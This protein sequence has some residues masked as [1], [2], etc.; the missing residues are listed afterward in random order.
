MKTVSTL[1]LLLLLAACSPSNSTSQRL[2]I[3]IEGDTTS[4]PVQKA[5][6]ILKL[7]EGKALPVRLWLVA[8]KATA[9]SSSS[10]KHTQISSFSIEQVQKDGKTMHVLKRTSEMGGSLLV[11][12]S[13]TRAEFDRA[14][15]WKLEAL[16][17]DAAKG[18]K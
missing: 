18:I 4:Q 13:G 5:P 6:E 3:L 15:A 17:T 2:G 16:V 12:H 14:A 1:W 11:E 10:N 7:I 8:E 9:T